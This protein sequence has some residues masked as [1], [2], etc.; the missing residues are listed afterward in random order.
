MSAPSPSVPSSEVIDELKAQLAAQPWDRR[1]SNGV[2]A[3]VGVVLM[4]V[5]FAAANG[6]EI[7]TAAETAIGSA[8][9]LLTAL[10]VLQNKNGLTPR[11]IADV[12]KAAEAASYGKHARQE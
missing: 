11:G 6:I 1:F 4:V 5:W 12:E 2:K 7:P 10:G 8:I 3:T 9:A